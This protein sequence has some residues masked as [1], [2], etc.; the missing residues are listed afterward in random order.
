M[1]LKIFTKIWKV[2]FNNI[3]ILA[4]L[5]GAL[6]K[7]HSEF[8]ISVVDDILEQIEVGLEQNNFKHNQRRIAQVKYLGE[9]YNYKMVDSQVNLSSK[10]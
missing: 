4:I 6:S 9:L 2:R 5:V 10:K 7:Y 3:H 1:L 8:S